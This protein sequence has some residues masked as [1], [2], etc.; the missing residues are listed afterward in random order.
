M[1]LT[2]TEI[3]SILNSLYSIQEKADAINREYS[4]EEA[5]VFYLALDTQDLLHEVEQLIGEFEHLSRLAEIIEGS[6]EDEFGGS[7]EGFV[8]MNMGHKYF[9]TTASKT[10]PRR[11]TSKD[12]E[13]HPSFVRNAHQS[14]EKQ[15]KVEGWGG[16]EIVRKQRE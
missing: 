3:D 7:M 1:I 14:V 15:K 8:E 16:F 12:N 2:N 5:D 9:G 10:I 6:P 11:I 13:V 4:F